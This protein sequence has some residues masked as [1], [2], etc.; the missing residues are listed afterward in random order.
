MEDFMLWLILFIDIMSDGYDA[1]YTSIIRLCIMFNLVIQEVW[2]SLCMFDD[3]WILNK[4][5]I[6]FLVGL[7][8]LDDKCKWIFK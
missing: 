8:G 2:L 7:V 4:L 1:T 3:G 6:K 5:H